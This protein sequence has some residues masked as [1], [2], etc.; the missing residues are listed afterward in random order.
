MKNLFLFLGKLISYI[1]PEQIFYYLGLIQS[2]IYTGYL[3]KRFKFFG[4]SVIKHPFKKLLGPEYISVGDNVTIH[5]SVV[6]TA[7]DNYLGN[8]FKPE[9]ILGDNSS[10]GGGCHISSINKIIIG[11]GVLL[12]R[13]I[14]LVDNSHGKLTFEEL[15]LKPTARDL[16]SKGPIIIKNNVWIGDKVTVLPGVIIGENSII[17]ANAVVTKNVP[18]NSVVVGVPAKVI[19]KIVKK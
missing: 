6:L 17:G 15:E 4:K 9:I 1:I 11:N 12:G 16:S 10:I 18:T 19:K 7:W 13:N 3:S 2:I 14:T 8:K 5:D